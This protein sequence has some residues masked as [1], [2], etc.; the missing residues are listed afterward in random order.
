VAS[1]PTPSP[2]RGVAPCRSA[3][4]ADTPRARHGATIP[5]GLT[6]LLQVAQL[7]DVR[8]YVAVDGQA[9]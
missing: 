7:E 5:L 3:R 9:G 4:P 6:S 1:L 8:K 2:G